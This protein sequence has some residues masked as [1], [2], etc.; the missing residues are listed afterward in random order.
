MAMVD[1]GGGSARSDLTVSAKLPSFALF[2]NG[3]SSSDYPGACLAIRSPIDLAD[4]DV[5]GLKLKL[6]IVIP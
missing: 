2:R 6:I 1:D 4:N 3:S 5:L